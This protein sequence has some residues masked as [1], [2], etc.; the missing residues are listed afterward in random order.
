MHNIQMNIDEIAQTI[1]TILTIDTPYVHGATPP[2][3]YILYVQ[4]TRSVN[5]LGVLL[6]GFECV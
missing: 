3:G 5:L 2:T 6:G 4:L 1:K